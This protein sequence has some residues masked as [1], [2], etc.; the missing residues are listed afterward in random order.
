MIES[1]PT[2]ARIEISIPKSE[3]LMSPLRLTN[4]I[5]LLRHD[6][7][8]SSSIGWRSRDLPSGIAQTVWRTCG[9]PCRRRG[10]QRRWSHCGREGACPRHHAAGPATRGYD[11]TGRAA[12][13]WQGLEDENNHPG[14]RYPARRRVDRNC[15][16]RVRHCR[17]I[18][19]FWSPVPLHAGGAAGRGLDDPWS[20][21]GTDRDDPEARQSVVGHAGTLRSDAERNGNRQSRRSGDGQPR[22]FGNAGHQSIHGET[23]HDPHFR[24]AACL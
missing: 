13:A 9:L 7:S 6:E 10:F 1:T 3:R 4:P 5:N 22:D 15:A 14:R 18:R 21:F 20:H 12:P 8:Y 11:R 24:Q 23:L 19:G 17:E 16:G 2:G